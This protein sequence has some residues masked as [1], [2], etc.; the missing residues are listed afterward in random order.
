MR[1]GFNI[2]DVFLYRLYKL[3][4]YCR[5]LDCIDSSAAPHQFK[6][7]V[8]IEVVH[9]GDDGESVALTLLPVD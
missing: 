7:I 3:L 5:A 9:Y 4:V 1:Y 2:H 8:R 6:Q